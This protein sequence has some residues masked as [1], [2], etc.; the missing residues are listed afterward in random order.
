MHA[1]R[2]KTQMKLTARDAIIPPAKLRDYLL[3][4]GH[5]DGW[6][7]ARYLARLGYRREDWGRLG[8][9][10][11]EQILPLEA[12]PLGET[13]WGTKYEILGVLSGPNGQAGWIRSI[14]IVLRREKRPRLVTLTPW[15]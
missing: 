6:S 1:G 3:S 11:R 4:E 5:P 7:K 2:S 9:D 12:C 13:P 14:W 8:R 15:K 10:L